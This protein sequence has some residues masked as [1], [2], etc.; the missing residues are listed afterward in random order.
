MID[1]NRDVLPL[2][3]R[4]DV[5]PAAPLPPAPIVTEYAVPGTMT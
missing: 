1:A 2:P 4:V 3:A 5:F